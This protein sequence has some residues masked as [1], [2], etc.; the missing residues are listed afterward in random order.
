VA[1][2]GQKPKHPVPAAPPLVALVS[3]KSNH[4]A[5]ALKHRF[6]DE[7]KR[8][9]VIRI[10]VLYLVACW[11][12][13]EPTHV[14]FHMLE[15]PPWA[16][17]L[18]IILMAIGFPLVLLFSW[19]YEV[20]PEGLK[21]TSEV[22]PAKSITHETGQKLNRAIIVVLSLAVI[23]LLTDKFWVSKRATTAEPPQT[24]SGAAT[25][26][27]TDQRQIGKA[28]AVN[29]KSI[30]VLPFADMSEKKDQEYFSD[31]LAEELIDQL[32]KVPQLHVIARTSA[33]S[34][35]GKS[36]DIPTIARKLN[37]AHILEGSV[38]KSGVRLR[39]TTQLIRANSGEDIWSETYDQ[40]LK[41][42]FKVQ[43]DIAGA[44]V[45]ALK[46]HLLSSQRIGGGRP[47]ESLE[48]YNQYLLGKQ[49]LYR[50][51]NDLDAYRRSIKSFRKA[52]ELDPNFAA[53]YAG[54]STAEFWAA[55]QSEDRS[56]DDRAMVAAEKAVALAPEQADGYWARGFMRETVS[57]DWSGARTD[58]EKA[59]E[60]AP[61]ESQSR[62]QYGVLLR[63]LGRLPEAIAEAQKAAAL[64]PLS[65]V[66]LNWL[67]DFYIE[68][69]DFSAAHEAIQRALEISPQDPYALFFLGNVLL[70]EGRASEAIA[71]YQRVSIESLHLCGLAMV[72]RSL[73]HASPSQQALDELIA[74]SSADSAYQIADVYA[75]RGEKEKAFEWLER[76]Y[77]QHDTGL[78]E[79]KTDFAL[80]NL[81]GDPRF[82]AMLRK[83]KLPE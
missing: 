39:V 19:V 36:D 5:L 62:V 15:V 33:F 68:N 8:R 83:L 47:T 16:N 6:F 9:N 46:V 64:D 55:E 11:V 43:D 79:L 23:A 2:H 73:G 10:G 61:G 26:S 24:M 81:H 34:F 13:L 67:A 63:D 4:P 48:A 27:A 82:G 28:V 25:V 66:V 7:L 71:A 56:G 3:K 59:L 74:K 50:G 41:D 78:V 1:K 40:E 22:D 80:A 14:V 58:L 53:A 29:E 42:V 30:A 52:I 60:L 32:A 54:L 77:R 49:I 20:T 18:V 21:P 57:W 65:N 51:A 38:R 45:A 31:G 17:R 76:A 75:W 44:V 69:G 37:V 72:E 12:I 70:R 35:K